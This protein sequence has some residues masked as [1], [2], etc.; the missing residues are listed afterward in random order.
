MFSEYE[1][2]KK[3]VYI[4]KRLN[5]DKDVNISHQQMCIFTLE[6]WNCTGELT[7]KSC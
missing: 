7:K 2:F 1:W 6:A 4:K 5:A 3:Y